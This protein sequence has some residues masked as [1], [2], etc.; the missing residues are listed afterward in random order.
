[1]PLAVL[2]CSRSWE[3][4][5]EIAET[6]RETRR[7]LGEEDV[8][9]LNQDDT[10]LWID[11]GDDLLYDVGG[12]ASCGAKMILLDLDDEYGQTAKIR[13]VLGPEARMP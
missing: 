5:T 4:Y 1:M 13:F 12:S 2:N 11:M 10:P 8:E 7:S 9:E 6:N 3:T